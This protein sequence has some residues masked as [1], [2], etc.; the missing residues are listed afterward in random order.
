MQRRGFTTGLVA[1]AGSLALGQVR[2][3]AHGQAALRR[4]VIGILNDQST[5]YRDDTGPLAVA[6]VRQAILDSGAAQ[7][8]LQVEVLVGDYQQKVDVGIELARRWVD[9][10]AVDAIIDVPNSALAL[11]VSDLAHVRDRLLLATSPGTAEL[12]GARCSPNTL[13]WT[14]DTW[15][16]AKCAGEATLRQGGDSWCFITADYAFGHAL[17]VDATRVVQAGGGRVLGSVR[18]PFPGTTD[19]S[20]FLVRAQASRA[21]VLAIANAGSD[22]TNTIKQAMEFGLPR[23]EPPERDHLAWSLPGAPPGGAGRRTPQRGAT[24]GG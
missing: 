16:V 21:K 8:G 4:V 13:H 23:R 9:L 15:M 5:N 20:S 24:A 6:A 11:A 18:H 7:R 14:Y 17:E 2:A 3:R 22:V 1:G 12:T 19:F 10:N